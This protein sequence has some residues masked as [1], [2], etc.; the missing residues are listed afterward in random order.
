MANGS[1]ETTTSTKMIVR[2]AIRI[3]SAISFGVL[4]RFAPSTR[5]IMRSRKVWPGLALICT[6]IQSESTR[7]PPVTALR[8]PPLSRMTGADSPVMADSS[9]EATPSTTSPSPGM[10]SPASTSTISP[11]RRSGA[12]TSCTAPYRSALARR[13]AI[14][15]V[16]ARRSV[17]ACALP[18]P[19]AIASAKLAK[20]TVNHSQMA[21][22]S[23]KS[24]SAVNWSLVKVAVGA[25]KRKRTN[26]MVVTTLPTSTTNIT[27]FLSCTRGSSFLNDSGIAP[28]MIL[29]S[30]IEMSPLRRVF[31]C[32][33][34]TVSARVS[35]G[36]FSGCILSVCILEHLPCLHQ[37]LFDNRSQRIRREVGQR[38]HDQDHTNQQ[39]HEERTRR[40]EGAQPGRHY[41]FDDQR[42]A[43]GQNGNEFSKAPDQHRKAHRPVVER[44]GGK[45]RE[46]RAVVA[47]GGGEGVQHLRETM[48]PG[49]EDRRETLGQRHGDARKA[50]DHQRRDQQGQHRHHDLLALDLLA[51][52]LRRAPH[53]EACNKDRDDGEHQ[54]GIEPR[55]NTSKDHFTERDVGDQHQPAQRRIAIVEAHDCT[56]RG[57]CCRLFPESRDGDAVSYLIALHVAPRLRGADLLVGTSLREQRIADLFG[58]ENYPQA[59]HEKDGRDDPQHPALARIAYPLAEHVEQACPDGELAEDNQHGG[60]DV[61]VLK[62]MGRIDVEKAATVRAQVFDDFNRGNRPLGNCLCLPI[63]GMHDRVG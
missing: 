10:T 61:G 29:G 62:G 2:L 22:A 17:S 55:A 39:G 53:H 12:A 20:T 45:S 48:R 43:K 51:Q 11:L 35:G 33:T 21:T 38:P 3:L 52:I 13:F 18:R 57:G 30:Q 59:D 50:Q 44:V 42:A 34:S 60:E 40:R 16:R 19:S 58:R 25:V 8:S 28:R 4:C 63:E 5:A 56:G 7:V 6:T 1:S 24:L 37:Q 23:T 26:S 49:V 27:G 14:V 36:I 41:P 32:L 9:T 54:H 31:H 47:I 46:S 15:V